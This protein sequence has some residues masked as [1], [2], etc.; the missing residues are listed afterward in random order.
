MQQP[1]PTHQTRAPIRRDRVAL[2]GILGAR[3][4][5]WSQRLLSVAVLAPTNVND[6]RA[7]WLNRFR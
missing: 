6:R 1:P 5:G 7:A 3:V 4:R 2:F